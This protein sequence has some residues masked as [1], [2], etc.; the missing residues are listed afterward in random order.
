VRNTG[1]P[2]LSEV[3]A[4][5]V[6]GAG[7][8]GSGI[9]QVAALGGFETHLHDPFPEALERGIERVKEGIRKGADR[10]RWPRER[11]AA[12]EGLLHPAPELGDLGGCE[13]VIEAAPESMEIK[14]ALFAAL[15]SA[16]APDAVLATNTSSLPVTA[17]A[18]A[19]EHPRRVVGMHFFNPVPFMQLLEVVAG[20]ESAAAAV[21]T[22]RAAGERM[23]KH[24]IV[25]RDVPGFLA[26]RCA[27]P[28][29]MEALRLLGERIAD[30][31]TIDRV[32]RMGGGFRMGPF[33]LADLVGI[34]VGFEVSKSFYDQSFHEPRWQPS[35]IQARMV[36]AGRFGR[37]SGRGYYDY[38]SSS[39]RDDD[40]ALPETGGGDTVA[41]E[42]EGRLAEEL[43]QLAGDVGHEIGF[44][45]DFN[46]GGPDLV[47]DASVGKSQA[48]S[49]IV[50]EDGATPVCLLCVDGSLAELDAGGG[51]VG[52]HAL[53]PL[54]GSGAVELTRSSYTTD[55]AATRTEAFFRSLGKHVEWVGDAPGLVLGRIVCQL[56]NEACFAL[57]EGVGSAADIDAAMRLG[58]NHP[59]GPLEWADL[60]E[61]DHV[62][63]T[64]DALYEERRE[65]RY[66]AAPL[67]RRMV[68]EGRLGQSTGEGFFEH[69]E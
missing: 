53:P 12:A 64:L 56:V 22:A 23:G 3:H 37:K 28:F 46:S 34:D 45:D 29:G 10:G 19:A 51:A 42:G 38:S 35:P 54:D 63:A 55:A 15:S 6:A 33:E 48:E 21:E 13:L 30:H 24:V 7:T 43:R 57:G 14:R 39:H 2:A 20:S 31:A 4:L 44:A 66:R 47:I 60:I 65:E 25:A 1:G 40:P 41:I 11:A 67:L 61:L 9:A 58:Y 32:V 8:M 17:L 50:I 16:C 62:L 52:F 69:D 68:A 5:G 27:R 18:S 26:N 36:Q 49:G 59:R